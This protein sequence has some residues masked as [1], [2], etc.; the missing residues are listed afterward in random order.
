M[1]AV[2]LGPSVELSFG[3]TKR[4]IGWWLAHAGGPTGTFGGASFGATKRCTGWCLTP[5][6]GATGAAGG[7]PSWDHETLYWVVP[8]ACG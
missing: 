6:G 4:Y 7:A 8:D 2:Q 3:A 1:R 5:A